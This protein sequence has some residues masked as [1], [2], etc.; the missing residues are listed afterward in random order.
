MARR[1]VSLLWVSVAW[2][3]AACIGPANALAD[4]TLTVS[5]V[6]QG[7]VSGEGIDC[8]QSGGPD[9][10]QFYNDIS[11]QECDPERRPPCF[12]ITEPP[13]VEVTA[14]PDSNGFSFSGWQGCDGME[15]RTCSSTITDDRG[16]TASYVDVQAPSVSGLSPSNGAHGGTFALSASTSDNAGVAKVEFR[17]RGALVGTDTSA[18]FGMSF[19]STGVSDGSAT[20]RATAYDAADNASFAESTITIDNSAPVVS[21]T[22]GPKQKTTKKRASFSFEAS[23][24]AS[25]FDCSLDGSA[26]T[27]CFSPNEFSVKKGRHEFSI[28]ATDSAG[29]E[30]PATLYKW[31]VIRRR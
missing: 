2:L 7:S 25:T 24:P 20:L 9:C 4:G 5:V 1:L 6:G 17:V 22:K 3:A 11:Y 31:K 29:N 18:P 15:G 13:L 12:T 8:T 30:G 10:S 19:D 16:V 28:R 14:G 27:E 26:F 21:I 23:E